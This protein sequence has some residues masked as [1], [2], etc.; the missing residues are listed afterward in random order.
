MVL[1]KRFI[2]CSELNLNSVSTAEFLSTIH[3]PGWCEGL[4][5]ARSRGYTA[6]STIPLH[7]VTYVGNFV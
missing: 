1:L 4:G 3:D 7:F 2:F 6:T 5:K